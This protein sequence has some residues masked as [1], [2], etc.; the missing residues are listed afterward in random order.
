MRY[1]AYERLVWICDAGYVVVSSASWMVFE[2]LKRDERSY[3]VAKADC[4]GPRLGAQVQRREG[5]SEKRIGCLRIGLHALRRLWDET[6]DVV[7]SH[8]GRMYLQLVARGIDLHWN[9]TPTTLTTN[10]ISP[11][12]MVIRVLRSSIVIDFHYL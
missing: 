9:Q 5:D 8:Q 11:N 4:H 6:S 3:A 1:D 12:I 10:A 2:A 7:S